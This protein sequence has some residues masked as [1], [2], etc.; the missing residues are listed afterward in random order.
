MKLKRI[1]IYI[2][3]SLSAHASS[4]QALSFGV[5]GILYDYRHYVA[6]PV[7][8]YWYLEPGVHRG[9]GGGILIYSKLD[10]DKIY[11]QSGLR[12]TTNQNGISAYNLEPD[13]RFRGIRV[14]TQGVGDA[15][16]RLETPFS[17]GVKFLNNFRVYGGATLSYDIEYRTE[18]YLLKTFANVPLQEIARSIARSYNPFFLNYSY[19]V[20]MDIGRFNIDLSYEKSM[21]SLTGPIYFEGQYYPF[22]WK[23]HRVMLSMG[24][25]ILPWKKEKAE[26]KKQ[27]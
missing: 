5:K 17:V 23:I 25:R 21:T 3:L 8:G 22:D 7:V 1:F 18:E 11:F 27:N 10:F 15:F 16:Y 9:Y 6:N 12:Y 20:G 13:R 4:G 19:G 24:F 14:R 2:G 26:S